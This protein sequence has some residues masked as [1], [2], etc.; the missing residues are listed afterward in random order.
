MAGLLWKCR[1]DSRTTQTASYRVWIFCCWQSGVGLTMIK[2]RVKMGA[3][4][5]RGHGREYKSVNDG[6]KEDEER[7]TK[8]C[9]VL[10][11]KNIRSFVV[12]IVE[13]KSFH[14]NLQSRPGFYSFLVCSSLSPHSS[15]PSL[16][17]RNPGGI[18]WREWISAII[19]VNG[20]SQSRDEGVLDR[21]LSS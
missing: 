17:P 18:D 21:V 13:D 16:I 4:K 5:W 3:N 12:V 19:F 8:T 6:W 20:V 1:T 15:A 14:R 11:D 10:G 7:E 2:V 9:F